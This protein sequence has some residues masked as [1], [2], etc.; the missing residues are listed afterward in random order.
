MLIIMTEYVTQYNSVA[1][2]CVLIDFGQHLESVAQ[3]NTLQKGFGC[4]SSTC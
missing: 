3:N 4:T 1:H 2:L